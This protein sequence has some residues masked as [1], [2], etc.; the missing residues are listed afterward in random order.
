MEMSNTPE[1]TPGP[2]QAERGNVGRAHPLF[3]TA[4]GCSGIRPW[5]DED[6][7]LIAAAPD[8][9]EQLGFARNSLLRAQLSSGNNFADQIATIDMWLAKAR[10]EQPVTLPLPV[11]A[12]P[13]YACNNLT[14]HVTGF[15]TQACLAKARGET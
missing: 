12:I 14:C 5:R 15:H 9:Y 8:L 3:V 2:W 13:E 7:H 1:W 11:P 4:P 6:A 10:G